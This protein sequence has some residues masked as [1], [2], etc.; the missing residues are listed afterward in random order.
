MA[1][2]K[3][4]ELAIYPVKSLGQI[5]VETTSVERFGFHM[6][7]RWMVVDVNGQMITQRKKSRMCLIQP[8]LEANHLRLHAANM[9]DLDVVC[10]DDQVRRAVTVW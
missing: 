3:I 2:I 9:P 10:S 6:D 7:R 4:S 8:T 1:E 5:R